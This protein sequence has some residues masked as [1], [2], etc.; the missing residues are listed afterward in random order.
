MLLKA[1]CYANWEPRNFTDMKSTIDQVFANPKNSDNPY[2]QMDAG[3]IYFSLGEDDKKT[4][5]SYYQKAFYIMPRE[6]KPNYLLGKAYQALSGIKSSDEDKQANLKNMKDCFDRCCKIDPQ[7][8][9][10]KE[11]SA[12]IN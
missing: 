11:V 1:A 10:C 5:K 9:Y 2:L 8:S 4:A 7:S 3:D 12:L 6:I